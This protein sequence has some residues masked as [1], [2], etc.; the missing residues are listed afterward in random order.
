MPVSPIMDPTAPPSW[1]LIADVVRTL[2]L[3]GIPVLLKWASDIRRDVR[4]Q[5]ERLK[6]VETWSEEH[7]KRDDERFHDLRGLVMGR[8]SSR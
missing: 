6:G 8:R 3:L 5:S 7:E 1:S 4:E 2:L